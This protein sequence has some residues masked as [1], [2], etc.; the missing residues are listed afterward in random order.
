MLKSSRFVAGVA[1]IIA[2]AVAPVPAQAQDKPLATINGQA[3]GEQDLAVLMSSLTQQLAQVPEG[4]RKRAALDRLIDMRILS[5][6]A[7]RQGLD[8]APEF[9]V[10]LDQIRQQLLITQ[11][12]KDKI[13]ATITD[14][15]LKAR[16]D[17]EAANFTPPEELRA[18]HVLVKTKDEAIAV[19]KEL[20]A[21]ADFAKEATDK[22]QDPGSAKQ[23]GDLGY[24]T[25]GDM[26]APFEEAAQ[27]LKIGEYT[28]EP[29]ETQFGFHVIKLEDRRK[30]KVPEFD[31]VK[32]QLRQSVVGEKF[33]ETLKGLKKDAKIE[34]NEDALKPPAK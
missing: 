29:V 32:D 23:G 24:F 13:E 7:A 5:A 34:I 27:K 11:F 1:M 30:Q 20:D 25:A 10:R 19:I 15:E 2:A 12:I 22:S 6:E 21:G 14:D 26:V 33:A 9:V 18:R 3:V 4:A 8:K 17:K 16:Y 28:K 31:Q